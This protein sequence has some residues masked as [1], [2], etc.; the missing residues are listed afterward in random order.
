MEL[1]ANN[2]F[3]TRWDSGRIRPMDQSFEASLELLILGLRVKLDASV[4]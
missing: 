2:A 4:A 1:L 3:L